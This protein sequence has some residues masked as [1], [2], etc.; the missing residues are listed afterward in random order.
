[1]RSG[2]I[3]VR[4]GTVVAAMW[5]AGAWIGAPGGAGVAW[6]Q[7][8]SA[9]PL[10]D[11]DRSRARELAIDE[12]LTLSTSEDPQVRANAIEGLLPAPARLESILPRALSDANEGVRT[13]AAIA[14]GKARLAGLTG[15]LEPMLR[16]RSAF[17]RAAAI[18][19]LRANG[20]AVNPTP[21]GAM[22]TRDASVRV[23]A[24]AAFLL[25]ELGDKGTSR[26][27]REAVQLEV[28]R[29]TSAEMKVL[30][31][32]IAEALVKLGDESQLHT[33]R[34]A[35]YPA[36]PEERDAAVLAVQ[37]LGQLGDRASI[38]QLRNLLTMRDSSGR[39]LPLEVRLAVQGA[40]GRLGQPVDIS[41]ATRALEGGEEPQ[42][43]QAAW[44]LGEIGGVDAVTRLKGAL[45]VGSERVRVSVAA[46]LLRAA[47]RDR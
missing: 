22:V 24:H 25:G 19:G 4:A 20:E 37:V 41:E 11:V 6:G 39:V 10:S 38:G 14:V 43:I 30:G 18:Y 47:D 26:L 23:R 33:I 17:V 44:A 46:G 28:P 32:Q 21:L 31:V 2:I 27:L 16:E 13:V 7:S 35:L 15:Q 29:T 42:R 40:L 3:G 9:A 36:T 8:G 1:M 12:L 5:L 34:A 45:G